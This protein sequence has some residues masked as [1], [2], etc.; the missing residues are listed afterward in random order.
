M[1]TTSNP[2]TTGSDHRSTALD[3]LRR[4]VTDIMTSDG[5]KRALEFRNRFHRYSFFNTSLI[6][7]QKPDATYVAGYRAWQQHNR[8]VRHGE[9]GITILAPIL[10]P[11][12]INPD[13]QTLTGFRPVKVFDISQTDG[14]P[15]PT[16]PAPRL[17]EDTPDDR[18]RLITLTLTLAR[19]CHRHG[20]SV[21]WD[22]QH[23]T[24]LGAYYPDQRHIA[25]KASLSAT[26][27][28]KT[29][30]HEAAHMLLHAASDERHLAEL[31]AE[32]TA[33]LVCHALGIDT[34][35]YSFAYLA[36]WTD[37][38]EAFIRAGDRASKTARTIVS[39]LAT[40]AATQHRGA[41]AV[42][43]NAGP[44]WSVAQ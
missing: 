5:W 35:S 8:Y 22:F 10:K 29:L 34:S 33:Y 16:K 15:I 20:V 17:L 9:T 4:G 23:P 14:D 12:P 39:A 21:T 2:M 27:G 40:A 26:Q 19:Y 42:P 31:E 37:D 3:I 13:E 25:I 30:V 36:S 7:A 44:T 41:T 28:F 6:L 43:T 1:T 11:D 38:I 18:A 32:T 24:A